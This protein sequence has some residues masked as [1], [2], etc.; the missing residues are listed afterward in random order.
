MVTGSSYLV[1]TS[2]IQF[3][4]DCGLYQG[5]DAADRKNYQPFPYDPR[6]LGF[7]ILTH[8]HLDHCGLIPKLVKNGF[9]GKSRIICGLRILLHNYC[10]IITQSIFRI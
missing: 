8:S 1:T 7:V 2:K 5:G 6:E 4:V 10:T 9:R 3:L